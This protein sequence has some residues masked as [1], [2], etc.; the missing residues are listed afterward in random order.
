MQCACMGLVLI[1]DGEY[2]VIY[3]ISRAGARQGGFHVA[4][5]LPSPC[6]C[7]ASDSQLFTYIRARGPYKHMNRPIF[8]Q[9]CAFTS[10][11]SVS[12]Q[13]DR[14]AIAHAVVIKGV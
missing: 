13:R 2:N 3:L 7:L 14:A 4:W 10:G 9:I 5:K 6:H 1:F 8:R 12:Q 11:K